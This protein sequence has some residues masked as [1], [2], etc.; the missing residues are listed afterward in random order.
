ME[1]ATCQ[2]HP[3]FDLQRHSGSLELGSVSSSVK[4]IADLGQR[5]ILQPA[6][7]LP[8]QAF[9]ESTCRRGRQIPFNNTKMQKP[10]NSTCVLHRQHQHPTSPSTYELNKHEA[11]SGTNQ[12]KGNKRWH[13]PGTI[14]TVAHL[15]IG[16]DLNLPNQPSLPAGVVRPD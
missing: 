13:Y 1:H 6:S 16:F 7:I 11:T 15:V 4:H 10:P 2:R 12:H 5:G 8:S 3:A 14:G 9:L